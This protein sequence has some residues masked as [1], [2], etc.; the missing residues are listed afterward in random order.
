MASNKSLRRFGNVRRLPS[1]RFQAR[2]TGPDGLERT[3]PS[4]FETARLASNWL[5]VV[6]SEILK[7][8]WHAPEAGEVG[9]TEYGHRWI[10]ERKLAPRTREGYEDLFRLHI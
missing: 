9:L 2:Y 8:E 3:A 7:G 10:A 4:T 1:G 5:T 6:E